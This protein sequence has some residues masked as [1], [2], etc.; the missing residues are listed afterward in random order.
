MKMPEK[1][2]EY[3]FSPCGMNCM[4]C[5]VHLKKKKPCNGCLGNDTD[6]PDRCMNCTIKSCA[7][8]KGYKYCFEC[9]EYPCKSITNLEKS[10]S[11]RYGVSLLE[12]SKMV[13][14]NGLAKFQKNEKEKW[15][16]T[17]CD[18]VMSLHDGMCSECEEKHDNYSLILKNRLKKK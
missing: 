12:N 11:K 13:N 9:N 15:K 18:G 8:G 5:Y 17:K 3:L 2:P 10:Y 14:E 4:V 7:N 16:C 6:K 1:I